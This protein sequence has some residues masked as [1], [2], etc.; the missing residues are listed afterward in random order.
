MPNCLRPAL[1]PGQCRAAR[2]LIDWTQEDLA[3]RAGL[4][5]STV[6]DFEKGRHELHRASAAVIRGAFEAAGIVMIEPLD[7]LGPGVRLA[8][9][10]E[11]ATPTVDYPQI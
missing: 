7:G 3:E 5:R 10:R 4:S 6:R 2:G 9:C 8:A 1:T 11:P